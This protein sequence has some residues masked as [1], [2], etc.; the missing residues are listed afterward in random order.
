[1]TVWTTVAAVKAELVDRLRAVPELSAYVLDGVP[2]RAEDVMGPNGDGVSVWLD[3]QADITVAPLALGV[4]RIR[5]SW[6]LVVTVQVVGLDSGYDVRSAEAR[7]DELVSAA[8]SVIYDRSH[9]LDIGL[10]G[11][12]VR[13]EDVA[14][15]AESGPMDHGGYSCQA[16]IGF[17]VNSDRC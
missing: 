7:R 11:W 16:T 5:E 6:V 3:N 1:M 4:G 2:W 9:V 10:D 12:T 13:L 8:R 15:T 17:Q 14:M